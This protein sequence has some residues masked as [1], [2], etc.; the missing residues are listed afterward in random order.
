M[1][2]SEE[3]YSSLFRN[4]M[5]GFAHC[6]MIYENNEVVDFIY[7]DVNDA[8]ERLTGLKK[9]VGKKVTEVIP[10]IKNKDDQLFKIYDRVIRTG[11]AEKFEY[12]LNALSMWFSVNV[13]RSSENN[14]VAIFDV[15]DDRKRAEKLLR[16]S[17]EKY[18]TLFEKMPD[19]VYKSTHA[20]KFI[21]VNPAFV[22]MLGYNS[23]E[24]L[25][26]V[27]IKTELYFEKSDRD[28][29][30]MQDKE[31]GISIYRLRKK[32]GSELWVEDRG[33]YVTDENGNII[34]HEGVLRNIT[35][36]VLS[37]EER[38]K[39]L[40]LLNATLESTADGILVVDTHGKVTNFN[41][42]FCEFWSIPETL[43]SSNDDN[44]LIAFVL[45]QLKNPDGFLQRVNE[46]YAS[47]ETASSDLIEFKDGR[48][49]ERYS[50]VQMLEGKIAG[51]VWSFRDITDRIKAEEELKEK[52]VFMET[53]LN[54]LDHPFYV[55]NTNDYSVSIANKAANKNFNN[56]VTTCY[57]LTHGTNKP[58]HELGEHCPLIET[59]SSK[60][61]TIVEHIHVKD[62]HQIYA[63]VHCY[64]IFDNE[65]NVSQVIE[66]SFDVTKR[67]KIE[68]ELKNK[69]TDLQKTNFE[70]D[71]FV[72]SVSH[73]L[74]APLSSMKGIIEISEEETQEPL[75]SEHLCMLKKNVD[76]LDSFIQ[77]ILDYSRNTRTE[78]KREKINVKEMLNDIAS[79]LKYMKD[80]NR[81]VEINID[82][83]DK[84]VFFSDK[85]RLSI[86]L[87]NLISNA[88]RYQNPKVDDPFVNIK[89][90]CSD[91]ETNIIVKDNG[92][93]IS[94]EMHEK[95]FDMFFRAAQNT[96]GSG[97]G[98][99]IVKEAVEKLN[100][101]IEVESELG[102]G[103]A[104]SIHI[105][106]N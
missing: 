25:L 69:N 77:D 74:R 8:F 68:Q 18:R 56:G 43:I 105:P 102:K 32:N 10:G 98:L 1:K 21:E 64:P 71:K 11:V 91:T 4:M 7:L 14:F 22:E 86:V 80:A 93:G 37:E 46:L 92:I 2:E 27:D 66:Y 54:S 45:S 23:K 76:K 87:S 65:N 88:I 40:S 53:V 50:Q 82:V 5:E 12:Y 67:K 101:K 3:K 103:T 38:K 85:S 104:F 96:E 51:R 59:M 36:R 75:M 97:L 15:I 42:K 44:K 89:V 35:A 24:E 63:E 70:L 84:T 55:I 60:R 78:I 106:K 31:K 62:G 33:Q 13:Y 73:D 95:I 39:T 79:H 28:D 57:A 17:E 9:I 49:F 19:G 29:A 61:S 94:K 52:N 16:E 48:T 6:K 26:A 90:D 81:K 99:Y 72:Y 34:Y 83:S 47:D 100:G 20:G 30:E 58:C 41:R